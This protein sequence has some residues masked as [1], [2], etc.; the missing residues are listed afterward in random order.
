MYRILILAISFLL[1][2]GCA[3]TPVNTSTAKK[4]PDERH[5]AF[6][7]TPKSPNLVIFRDEG[8]AGSGC[9]LGF[10]I[11]GKLAARI[12]TGEYAEFYVE[13]GKRI[14]ERNFDPQGRG[15]CGMGGGGQAAQQGT[16]IR[17]GEIKKLR[18]IYDYKFFLIFRPDIQEL[19]PY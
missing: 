16:I 19:S 17:D 15:L 12:D 13:S 9:Y 14:L 4:I 8:F 18:L 10:Y 5:L 11:D 6:K 7:P 1:L 3:S 2:V